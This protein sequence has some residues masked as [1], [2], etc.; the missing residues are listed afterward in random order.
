MEGS[1]VL[2]GGGV[3]TLA[4]L[5]FSGGAYNDPA[6]ARFFQRPTNRGKG[7]S[8]GDSRLVFL[9]FFFVDLAEM[10]GDD[11][12]LGKIPGSVEVIFG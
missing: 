1:E 9:S 3:G 4:G 7:M 2:K 8:I 12:I 6:S 11:G 5:S 10:I